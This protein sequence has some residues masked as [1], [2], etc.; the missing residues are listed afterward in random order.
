MLS[1]ASDPVRFLRSTVESFIRG[2]AGWLEVISSARWQPY[3]LIPFTLWLVGAVEAIQRL[4]G[5]K[6]DPRFWM[7]LS[8]VMTIYTGIRIFRLSGPRNKIRRQKPDCPLPE[9]VDL[10][11]S[12]G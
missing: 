7:S 1:L 4:G 5:Q 6:L 12:G 3:F 8:I 2:L 9:I 10:F 11:R